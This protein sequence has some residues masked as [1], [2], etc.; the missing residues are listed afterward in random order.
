MSGAELRIA[1]NAE[2]VYSLTTES[3]SRMGEVNEE[4]GRGAR[5]E[6][7]SMAASDE[8]ML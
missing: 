7:N 3:G 4:P 1:E 8:T 2:A 6:D 5:R